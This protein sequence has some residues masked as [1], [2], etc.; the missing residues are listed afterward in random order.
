V[1]PVMAKMYWKHAV[2]A[3]AGVGVVGA[4]IRRLRRR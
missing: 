1:L 3:L 4:V 2:A